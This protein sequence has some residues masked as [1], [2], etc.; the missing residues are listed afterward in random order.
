MLTIRQ[1]QLM[2]LGKNTIALPIWVNYSY[3]NHCVLIS[4]AVT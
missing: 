1:K 4:T 2:A 3:T